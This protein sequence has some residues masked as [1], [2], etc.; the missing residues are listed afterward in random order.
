MVNEKLARRY[1][2][3]VFSLA[4]ERGEIERVGTDLQFVAA[5]IEGDPLTHEFFVAPVIDRE[6]K[7]QAIEAA[8]AGKV[9]EIALH[10][11]LLLVRKRRGSLLGTIVS[12]YRKLQR[13]ARGAETLTLTSA[14]QLEASEVRALVERLERVYGKKFDVNQVVDP[15]LIG[16]VRILMGDRRVD[17][18]VSGRLDAL[19]RTLFA[20]N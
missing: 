1:A 9:H 15:K 12:E 2:V 4:S 17:G 16:G 18:T 6:T 5:Q 3:A 11:V 14:R 20:T 8:F 19:A 7:Q 10:T 13:Q